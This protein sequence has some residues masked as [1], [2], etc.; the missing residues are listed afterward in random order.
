MIEINNKTKSR[1]NINLVKRI[2]DK[3]LLVN[4]KKD[5]DVSIAFIGDSKM[6]E[7]NA[8]YRDRDR[9]TDILAFPD[10]DD[11]LG[12]LIINYAQIK[13]QAKKF[14][15]NTEEE[16]VFILV[17]GLLHLIGYEDESEEGKGEMEKLG[18]KFIKKYDKN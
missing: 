5:R 18:K 10:E 4:K 6:K 8:I 15:N 11:D 17:H 2:T 9:V 3:F 12:E 1:I 7:L 14:S 16:L 13:R